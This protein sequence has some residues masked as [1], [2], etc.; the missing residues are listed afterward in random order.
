MVDTDRILVAADVTPAE[1]GVSRVD[2]NLV[3]TLLGTGDQATV[4]YWFNDWHPAYQELARVEFAADGTVWDVAALKQRVLQGTTGA[5]TLIGY[6]SADTLIG[7]G[8]ADS[9]YGN[10]GD[11]RLDGGAGADA[12]WGGTGNDTYVV[13]DVNDRVTESGG[14]GTD[15]V[16]SGVSFALPANVENLTLTGTGA[17]NATGNEAANTLRGNA[18][19]N[20][21]DGGPGADIM[22]GGAGNDTYVV[23]DAG[24]RI[25]E[26]SGQGID[27]VMSSI[28]YTLGANLE[29]LTLTGTAAINAAGNTLKNTLV[30][31]GAS[32][33]LSGGAGA[34]TMAGGAGNDTYVVDNAGDV[35]TEAAGE[36]TDTVQ[37][38]LSYTLGASVEN[39]TLT[40]SKAING[41]GNALGNTLTGNTAANVLA[42]G[43]GN[44]V[45]SGGRGNDTYRFDRG[46]GADR[47]VENDATS[48]NTDTALFGSGIRPLDVILT[49]SVNSL[50]VAL[51]ASTDAVT[52]Q[53]WYRGRAYQV[54][55]IQAGDGSRLLA[56]Q[57]GALIQAMAS[58]SQS[59]G[60]SW[61]QAVEQ[62]PDDVT[63]ILAAH[64]QPASG[65]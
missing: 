11:D 39:L 30:G 64:W 4:P 2:D 44:D 57:V 42:G 3:V 13:D 47:I 1:V 32:N 10:G 59:T 49:R 23:D 46:M 16:L 35:V 20:V 5:D 21:L 19:A 6:E 34:D 52:V 26:L 22:T 28:G 12:M 60:L 61:S 41:T 7:L 62:R 8:G 54:E 29:N 9:L 31:N 50:V 18:A 24:D 38:S 63:A 36:G 51:Q 14:Q 43:A 15:T 37:A 65:G 55:V 48:G 27:T 53:D 56:A 58:F 33:V 25:T 45:L 40:G 17:I